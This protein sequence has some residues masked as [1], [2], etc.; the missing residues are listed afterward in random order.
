MPVHKSR[1][2]AASWFLNSLLLLEGAAAC[3]AFTAAVVDGH[4]AGCAIALVV[5]LAGA[6]FAGNIGGGACRLGGG[7]VGGR[8]TRLVRRA[9][10]FAAGC[11]VL[12]TH[13]DGR[14]GAKAGAVVAAGID[15]TS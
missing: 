6:G 13:I 10:R 2:T 7:T 1:H 8:A 15:T 11:G 4:R 3:A 14:K 9:D 5:V 12:A